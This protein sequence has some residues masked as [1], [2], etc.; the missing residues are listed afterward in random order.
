MIPITGAVTP[1]VQM[2]VCMD[3]QNM[4]TVKDLWTVFEHDGLEACAEALLTH[5][6]EDVEVS[7]YTSQG[8]VLHGRDE[9]REYLGARRNSGVT[10]DSNAWT[11]EER[12]DTVIVTASVRVHR[13]DGSLADAQ[14]QWIYGFG[15][16]GRVRKTSFAPLGEEPS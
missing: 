12:D 1:N 4:R 11:F 16:D 9:V 8:R 7:S 5:A 15:E 13:P 2:S 14:V 6:S 10:L 3:S